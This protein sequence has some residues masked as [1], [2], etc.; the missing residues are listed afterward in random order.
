MTGSTDPR[1]F[2]YTEQHR[3][4]CEVRFVL[5]M[6]SRARRA[7]YLDGVTHRR[8]QAAGDALRQAVAEA[9]HAARKAPTPQQG[10]SSGAQ[11]G[12]V[13]PTGERTPKGGYPGL[14]SFLGDRH[15]GDSSPVECVESGVSA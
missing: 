2:T 3:H 6:P 8:G 11:R 1:G 14:G 7:E 4:E 10:G 15:E 9:W 13:H 5:A 12:S